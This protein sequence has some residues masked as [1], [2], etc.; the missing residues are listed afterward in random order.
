MSGRS[1]T[2]HLNLLVNSSIVEFLGHAQFYDF[3]VE[4]YGYWY[5]SPTS[6]IYFF[7]DLNENQ[8]LKKYCVVG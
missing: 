4:F 8:N 2:V 5:I 3:F 6:K 1:E 7:W